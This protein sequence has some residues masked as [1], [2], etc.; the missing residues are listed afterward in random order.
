MQFTDSLPSLHLLW[1]GS[2]YLSLYLFINSILHVHV[3]RFCC[4]QLLAVINH[5]HMPSPLFPHFSYWYTKHCHQSPVVFLQAAE[6]V[7]KNI[8]SFFFLWGSLLDGLGIFLIKWLYISRLQHCGQV[9]VYSTQEGWLTGCSITRPSHIS[10]T[11][12]L[13]NNKRYF[14]IWDPATPQAP[15][16]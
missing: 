15:L 6:P 7:I 14:G 3:N 10:G 11:V 8:S 2:T 12:L 9:L 13:I 5:F 16:L 1:Q 4:H